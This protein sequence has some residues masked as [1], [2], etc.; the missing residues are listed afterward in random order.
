MIVTIPADAPE[1]PKNAVIPREWAVFSSW[2]TEPGDELREYFL[3][4]QI[5]YPDQTPFGE[6]NKIRINIERNKR[7][8]VN[9]Q[10]LAFPIG[11]TGSYTVKTSV[12]ENQRTVFSPIEFKIE[13]EIVKQKQAQ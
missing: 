6:I 7:A 13:L 10:M 1:V 4:T 12:E 9:V 2:D 5:L 11:Q 3:C 8:Q